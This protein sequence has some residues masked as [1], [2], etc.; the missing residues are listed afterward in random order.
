MA[1]S[2]L[3]F[4][5]LMAKKNPGDDQDSAGKMSKTVQVLYAYRAH[6]GSF[7]VESKTMVVF[8]HDT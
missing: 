2:L 3:T 6:D 5:A 7:S 1:V 4:S 8:Q